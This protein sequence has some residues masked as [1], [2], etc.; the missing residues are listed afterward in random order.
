MS[1]STRLTND[2][3]FN[4]SMGVLHG[5]FYQAGLAFS[6]PTT[7]L[8]V[9]LNHFT[10]SLA[11]IGLFSAVVT[12]GGVLPQLLVAHRIRRRA[13]AKP[14]LVAAIWTRAGAWAVLGALTWVCAGCG[15]RFTLTSLLVLLLVFSTAGGVANVPFTNLWGKTLP[16]N[17]RGRFWAHRQLWGGLLAVGSGYGVK[18]V[19]ASPIA[20]PGNYALLFFFSFLLMAFGYV[21][22]S[23]VR[24]PPSQIDRSVRSFGAYLAEAFAVLRRDRNFARFLPTQIATM[25]FSFAMPFYVLYGKNRLAMPAEQVGLLISVQMGG[26]IASNLLWGWLSDRFGNRSVIRLTSAATLAMPILALAA[27]RSGWVLLVGVFALSGMVISGS[28]IGFVNYVLE[29]APERLRPTYI[30]ISGTVNGLFALL[31]IAGGWIV[32]V[33]SYQ[34]AFWIS[35][36]VAAVSVLLSLRLACLRS[37]ERQWP[38]VGGV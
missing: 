22:L 15:S 37:S 34:A 26:A 27:G 3:K 35:S 24:E 21:A 23:S 9:F 1:R 14:V 28:G 16:V 17:L 13:Q 6:S 7:V 31:P 33:A 8:P 29:V 19:L 30:A 25:F 12:A 4:F 5:V 38:Q 10:G 32:D 2:L 36:G 20:F 18:T 11:L